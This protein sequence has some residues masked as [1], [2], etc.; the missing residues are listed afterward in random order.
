MFKST[1][2]EVLGVEKSATKD[3]IQKAFRKSAMHYHPDANPSPNADFIFKMLVE[4]KDALL[5][6]ERR[7]EYDG[8]LEPQAQAPPPPPRAPKK[9]RPKP[10]PETAGFFSLQQE[11]LD[12][13]LGALRD[14]LV[15]MESTLDFRDFGADVFDGYFMHLAE[16]AEEHISL[17][18]THGRG[19]DQRFMGHVD[20]LGERARALL[21]SLEIQALADKR[22]ER[23]PGEP[24]GKQLNFEKNPGCGLILLMIWIGAWLGVYVLAE[25]VFEI[26]EAWARH[27]LGFFSGGIVAGTLAAAYERM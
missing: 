6:D 22:L 12:R 27:L 8:K 21:D 2:Y 18:K 3:E 17:C 16:L 5:D 1:Y 4:A 23:E 24:V 20:G 15:L 25:G 9:T 26:S 10:K 13:R 7:A 11:M 19:A 14:D